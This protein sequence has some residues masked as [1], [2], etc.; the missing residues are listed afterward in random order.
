MAHS[1]MRRRESWAKPLMPRVKDVKTAKHFPT[2]MPF[3]DI[4]D[5]LDFARAE[6]KKT[7]FDGQ[8]LGELK[9][10]QSRYKQRPA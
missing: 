2:E 8:T 9:Q 10:Y 5:F 4:S 7:H 1:T 3:S 6:T